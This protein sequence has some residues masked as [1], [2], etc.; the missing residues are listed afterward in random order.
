MPHLVPSGAVTIT[1]PSQFG[2]KKPL[3]K[4]TPPPFFGQKRKPLRGPQASHSIRSE[5]YLQPPNP[6]I[7]EIIFIDKQKMIHSKFK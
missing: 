1:R 3:L 4:P 6:G 5:V 2:I 7:I